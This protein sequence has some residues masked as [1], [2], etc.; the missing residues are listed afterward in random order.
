VLKSL[1]AIIFFN[2]YY[3]LQSDFSPLYNAV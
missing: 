3:L 2:Y 1:K